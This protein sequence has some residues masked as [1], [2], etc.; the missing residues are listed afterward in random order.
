MVEIRAE[1]PEDAEFV[2]QVHEAA[3]GSSEEAALVDSLR[4]TVDPYI[5]LVAVVEGQVVGHVFVS[6]VSLEPAVLIPIA[7]LAPVGVLPGHQG[8]GVGG[9]LVRSALVRASAL[10]WKAVFLVGEPEY[11]SRF[12]F[13]MAAPLGFHYESKEF[14]RAFQVAEVVPGALKRCSGYVRYPEAFASV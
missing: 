3:F 14:D 13:V 11:Y 2:F 1:T 10:G 5:S 12:G 6:P 8:R 9:A 4:A 7:G